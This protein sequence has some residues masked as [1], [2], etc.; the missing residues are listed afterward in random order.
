MKDLD[1]G[2]TRLS[3]FKVVTSWK[4]EED[5]INKSEIGNGEMKDRSDMAS[6]VACEDGRNKDKDGSQ[7]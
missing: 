3:K 1:I 2:A 6:H 7:D 5:A 4:I